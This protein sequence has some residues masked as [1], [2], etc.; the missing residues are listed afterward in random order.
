MFQH[1]WS[2]VQRLQSKR[3]FIENIGEVHYQ[4]TLRWFHQYR[5]THYWWT[6]GWIS[7]CWDFS[8]DD[9]FRLYILVYVPPTSAASTVLIE[10]G[11]VQSLCQTIIVTKGNNC[12]RDARKVEYNLTCKKSLTALN[13]TGSVAEN[14]SYQVTFATLENM[15]KMSYLNAKCRIWIFNAGND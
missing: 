4:K 1:H 5:R 15:W 8:T 7:W 3:Y 13:T 14:N 11:F 12:E 2:T 6:S 10:F 9:R